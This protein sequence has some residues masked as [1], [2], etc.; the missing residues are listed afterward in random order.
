MQEP[1]LTTAAS[2]KNSFSLL[3]ALDSQ[4]EAMGDLFWDDGEAVNITQWGTDVKH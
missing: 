1:A 2:R 4:E 3:V